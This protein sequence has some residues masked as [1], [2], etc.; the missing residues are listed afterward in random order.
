MS[1]YI[2]FNRGDVGAEGTCQV[3]DLPVTCLGHRSPASCVYWS[4]S[5]SEIQVMI[6]VFNPPWESGTRRYGRIRAML[7][8]NAGIYWM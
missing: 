1:L 6:L 3:G 2:S 7:V 4:E 5:R 8:P